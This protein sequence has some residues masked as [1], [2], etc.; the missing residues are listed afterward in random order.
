MFL[1]VAGVVARIHVAPGQA[2]KPGDPLFELDL[3]GEALAE[4]QSRL[5][6]DLQQIATFQAELERLG[7]LTDKGSVAAKQRLQLEYD[8]RRVE[9]QRHTRVQELLIRGLNPAQIDRIITDQELVKSVTVVVPE[10]PETTGA[11]PLETQVSAQADSGA[12]AWEY[13]VETL[14]V[15]P[16]E[17]ITPDKS[18]ARLARHTQLY[19]QGHAFERDVSVVA[20]VGIDDEVSVEIG[21]EGHGG[22]DGS[23]GSNEA[24][25]SHGD[26]IDGLKVLYL[27]NHVDPVTQTY[28]FYV[29][30]NNQ[31]LRDV[32]D[33]RG[34]VFR[35]WRFKP[36]QRVHIRLPIETMKNR[37]VLPADAVVSEGPS[38][39]IF[40]LAGRH[41]V[42]SDP[43]GKRQ[44]AE[45]YEQ[46]PVTV[47]YRNAEAAVLA[48]SPRLK[49]GDIIAM[50][51]AYQ[52]YLALKNAA[53]GGGDHHGHQH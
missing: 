38:S 48:D 10:F 15:H 23:V 37:I 32:V 4:A 42:S 31:V 12:D 44:Y 49:D 14:N 29:P 26:V 21:G 18:L 28:A 17:S 39:Y 19:V 52:L 11:K 35:S 3:T 6:D 9:G 36:G 50:N 5:L 34:R 20:S 30:L 25:H 7:P 1:R 45:E 41:A 2:V 47:S 16:G 51:R 8:L 24:A 27:D 33:D 40:K 53:G 43:D 22:I 13:T 46:I